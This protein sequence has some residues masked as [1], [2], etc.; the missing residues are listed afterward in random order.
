MRR[1]NLFVILV[2][3]VLLAG[4]VS[5]VSDEEMAEA[6][7]LVD[8]KV[9]C[10]ELDDSQLEMI[11]EY[12]MENLHPGETHK[13]MDRMMGVEEGTE[14]HEQFHVALAKRMYCGDNVG[15]GGMGSMMGL[16]N[17][18]DFSGGM[19]Q[20]MSYSPI[21]CGFGASGVW[22]L[23]QLLVWIGIF[24]LVGWL[25]YRYLLDGT[26]GSAMDVLKRRYAK[27]EITKK[28]FDEMRKELH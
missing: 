4:F 14:R 17:F 2:L 13:F 18:G 6:K 11:G 27:G 10:S 1:A 7:A 16:N 28:Q 24:V 15:F 23:M 9:A 26:H 8:A 5:S 25:A 20:M 19:T 22:S 3:F 21:G 12:Y